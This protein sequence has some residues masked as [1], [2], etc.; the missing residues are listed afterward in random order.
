M[1]LTATA[2]SYY[3]YSLPNLVLPSSPC[4]FSCYYFHV[5]VVVYSRHSDLKCDSGVLLATCQQV[6]T[7]LFTHSPQWVSQSPAEY[8]Y[9]SQPLLRQHSHLHLC[10]K[11]W[12]L[13][14]GQKS[15]F[16]PKLKSALETLKGTKLTGWACVVGNQC[17]EQGY[18]ETMKPM[19]H[20]CVSMIENQNGGWCDPKKKEKTQW[21]W[22]V[23]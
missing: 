13:A 12:L 15:K 11:G 8:C 3:L 21:Q 6:Q 10:K 7:P 18:F 23:C 20:A 4:Y 2:W 22:P 5:L 9:D 1:L 16:G 14:S 19:I 17:C